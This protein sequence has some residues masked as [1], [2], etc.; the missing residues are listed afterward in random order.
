MK[1]ISVAIITK[2]EEKNIGRCLASVQRVA[3]EIVVADS[4]S[5]DATVRIAEQY[6]AK[7]LIQPFLGYVKQKNFVDGHCSKAWVLSLDADEELSP[8]LETAILAFKQSPDD[9]MVAYR[10]NRLTNYCGSWIHHCGWYP[11]TKIRLFRKDAGEWKGE[12]IHERWETHD[13]HAPIGKL[14][15]DILH[16]SYYT[17]SDHV[18]Q[19]EHF[20]EIMARTNAEKGKDY[21]LLQL[22]FAPKWRFFQD[23]ILKLGFLDGFAGYQVCK[24]SAFAT[25]LKYAKTRQYIRMKKTV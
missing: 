7:V 10:M 21:S 14:K 15:G 22:F 16:Y 17:F 5:E 19:I 4:V 1:E 8:E 11:D 3:D 25:Y 13:A 18:R 6:G 2:N 9:N 23:Y 20:T 24:L 12:N